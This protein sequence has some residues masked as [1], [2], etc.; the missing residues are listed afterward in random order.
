MTVSNHYLNQEGKTFASKVYGMLEPKPKSGSGLTNL[1]STR[2]QPALIHGK[3]D[4]CMKRLNRQVLT[5]MCRCNMT[6]ICLSGDNDFL[7]NRKTL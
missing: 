6:L 2:R 1:F 5:E 7:R 3:T 4:L